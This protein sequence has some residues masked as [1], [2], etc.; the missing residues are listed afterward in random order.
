[1]ELNLQYHEITRKT[2]LSCPNGKWA[3]WKEL[4]REEIR[5]YSDWT[6]EELSSDEE[7]LQRLVWLLAWDVSE[8]D[9]PDSFLANEEIRKMDSQK[10]Q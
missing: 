2:N 8:A 3:N 1:M 10:I 9:D 4:I 5:D 6:E 7:N